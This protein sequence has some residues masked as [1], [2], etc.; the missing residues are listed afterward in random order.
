MYKYT[1]WLLKIGAVL[2]I[3]FLLQTLKS[4]MASVD[5]FIL[6]PAQIL[7]FVSAYRCLFPVNYTTNTVLHDSFMSSIFVTRFLA[8]FVEVAYIYQFSY[9]IRIINAEQFLFID[10]LSWLMVVQVVASQF[11]VWSAILFQKEKYYYYEEFGWAIIFTL[12]AVSSA[13]LYLYADNLDSYKTLLIL[14]LIFAAFYL[15]WQ[16]VH[17]KSIRIRNKGLKNNFEL[18]F[19]WESLIEGLKKSLIK[20]NKSDNYDSWGGLV[21]MSWMIG[22]WIAVIPVWI[23]FIIYTF[24]NE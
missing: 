15:P 18:D 2:N 23:F 10:F 5:L 7:F 11:F 16:T 12:N 20:K 9:I 24:S 6:L 8:T 22:Y 3:Y 19:N 4:P 1:L 21:G 14:N 13:I 17:L